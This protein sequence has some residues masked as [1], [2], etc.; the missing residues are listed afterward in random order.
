MLDGQGERAAVA[1]DDEKPCEPALTLV[2]SATTLGPLADAADDP[3]ACRASVIDLHFENES[4]AWTVP[5]PRL[6]PKERVAFFGFR[7]PVNVHV[8]VPPPVG[9]G[10]GVVGAAVTVFV[11]AEPADVDP[12]V[13]VAITTTRRVPP[14]SGD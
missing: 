8:C 6:T 1:T 7:T 13:F 9:G 11:G 2:S 3:D 5:V 12:P 14:T 4:S 10:G